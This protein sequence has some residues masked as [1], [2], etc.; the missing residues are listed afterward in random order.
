V[1]IDG[2]TIQRAAE[3]KRELARRY[4]GDKV[5]LVVLRG[6]ERIEREVELVAK[7]KPYEHPL[8]GILPMRSGDGTPGVTVRYVYPNGPAAG[9]GI[10]PG[11]VIVSLAGKPVQDANGLRELPPARTD[12]KPAVDK[13]PEVGTVSLKIPEFKN[14]ALLY[15][16]EKYSPAVPHGLVIWLHAPGGFEQKDLV[17]RWKPLCERFDLMLLAPKSGDPAKWE[18]GEIALVQKLL[19]K[20]KSTYTVDPARV[21]LHGHEGGGTMAYMVTFRNREPIRA[22]AAIDATPVGRPPDNDPLHRLAIYTTTA[23]K[24]THARDVEQAVTQFRDMKIPVT[25]KDLGEDARYLDA[26]ELAELA[27]WIDMLDRI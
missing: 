8:V 19:D 14:E 9:A 4:A 12:G 25:V 18:P 5:R 3:V 15:V 13:R 17:A 23:K 27:R 11:D 7:L 26:D 2:R 16:P 21:V 24:S 20:V 10:Q 22:V 1:E 6:K